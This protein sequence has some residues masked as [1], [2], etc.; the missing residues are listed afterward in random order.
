LR[1]GFEFF[2]KVGLGL[3]LTRVWI[4]FW[5]GFGFE[6]WVWVFQRDGFGFGVWVWVFW[7]SGFGFEVWVWV[8]DEVGLGL[9]LTTVWVFFL[10]IGFL[11]K[12]FGEFSDSYFI[13]KRQY[14]F[15]INKSKWPVICHWY[16]RKT[17]ILS[18]DAE[19]ERFFSHTKYV[20]D[21]KSYTI[22]LRLCPVML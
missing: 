3:G 19:V 13:Q 2:D 10:Q 21:G 11:M 17:P 1:C 18:S 22:T 14:L 8:F 7:P 15:Q 16:R 12:L 5:N 9:G 6:V 4:I 20:V